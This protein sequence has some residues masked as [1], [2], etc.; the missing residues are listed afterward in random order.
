MIKLKV[1]E[2]SYQKKIKIKKMNDNYFIHILFTKKFII[3]YVTK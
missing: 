1:Q 2:I 3:N